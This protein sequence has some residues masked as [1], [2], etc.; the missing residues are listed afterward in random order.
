M[1]RI[2]QASSNPGD[3]VLDPFCGCGTAI[4]AAHKLGRRW[5]G[6]DVTHLAI[7]LQKFRLKDSF[8]L[9][10][11]KNYD[12]IGEP[13]DIGAARQLAHDDRYQFQ[14]WALSLVDAK[15]I[16]GEKIGRKGK[17]AGVD[18]VINVVDGPKGKL[19]SVLIQVK[20]GHV[21]PTDVRDLIGVIDREKAAIGVFI[22]LESPS[23]DM[24]K[25]AV[26]AGFYHSILWE[27]DYPRIQIFTVEQLMKGV[28]VDMPP[29]Y[30]PYK[31]AEAMQTPGPTQG[32]LDL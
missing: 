26:S 31:K 4:A 18:G 1:E 15:P 2:I 16:G 5:A 23:K 12:V 13:E 3:L 11:C 20:S 25:E 28:R 7:T 8:G 30:N 22:T 32:K 9:E 19:A 17:D 21:R 29:A 10:A 6:I 24:S 27:K 14:W